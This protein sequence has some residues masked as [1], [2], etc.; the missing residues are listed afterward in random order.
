LTKT[1]ADLSAVPS[2]KAAHGREK[3]EPE[4]VGDLPLARIAQYLWLGYSAQ[5]IADLLEC[6]VQIVKQMKDKFL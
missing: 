2:V 6:D 4:S 1:G 5:R 3:P